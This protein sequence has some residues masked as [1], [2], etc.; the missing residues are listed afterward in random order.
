MALGLCVIAACVWLGAG[1]TAGG[2]VRLAGAWASGQFRL[3]A[4]VAIGSLAAL[5]VLAG[6]LI[7]VTRKARTARGRAL[8]GQEGTAIIEFAMVLPIALAIVLMMIQAS[9]LMGGFLC[10]N[11]A[12]YCAARAAVVFVP[13]VMSDEPTN[14]LADYFDPDVSEKL[15]RIRQAAVWAVMPVSDGGYDE[16]SD[17]GDVLAEGLEEL[18]S[19]AGE[20]AP[21]WVRGYLGH[22]LAY[23]E[24]NTDVELSPPADGLQYAAH[25][26]L[27]VVT[28]HNLYLSVPYASRVLAALDAEEAVEFGEGRYA[29]RVEIPC[30]LRNEGLRDTIDLYPDIEEIEPHW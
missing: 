22:K 6:W 21:G 28:R 17:Y 27:H 7:R 19:R 2:S 12:S 10:V 14:V 3:F 4:Y 30:T 20:E 5:A 13:D 1:A 24:R 9:L 29:L 26:D 11:Y 15:A 25:E 8:G 16:W 18:Y 23:A